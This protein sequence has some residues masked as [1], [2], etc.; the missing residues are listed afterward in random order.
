MLVPPADSGAGNFPLARVSVIRDVAVRPGGETKSARH[1]SA[2]Y[3]FTV[4]GLRLA[5][6]MQQ[7]LTGS[8]S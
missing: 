3:P 2:R 8:R 1:K 4:P 7:V 6:P 5:W